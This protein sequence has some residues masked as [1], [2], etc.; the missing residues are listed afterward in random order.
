M[1]ANNIPIFFAC[2]DNYI[3]YLL[4]TLS[5]LKDHASKKYHYDL[6]IL[7]D[8]ISF[9]NRRK[10]KALECDNISIK[11]VNVTIRAMRLGDNLGIRDYYTKTTYF[12][13]L[14]PNLYPNLDKIL[15]LDADIVILEDI[16]N[17]YLTNIGDNLLGA[18]PDYSVNTFDEFAAYV[19]NALDIPRKRYMNAGILIMN[20]KR[21]RETNFERRTINL[22][23]TMTFPV[24][25]DQDILNI[26]CR[27]QIHYFSW[28]WDAMPLGVHIENPKIVH[29]NLIFKPWRL[30]DIP[31][32]EHF[33]KY[34]KMAGVY[35]KI[36]SAKGIVSPEQQAKELAELNNLKNGCLG[37]SLRGE[38]YQSNIALSQRSEEDLWP[39]Q[40]NLQNID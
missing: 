38:Y 7:F 12:R 35:D 26:I 13:L 24:A 8:H 19:E 34:A 6:H 25:Q 9:A 32:E 36:V 39:I 4:V 29:F 14:L 17:L 23:D 16:A 27:G 33:W 18:S 2:D 28:E 1:K 11:F 20:L 5:S 30:N 37:E 10:V 40:L 21:M 15:Y 31:Y 22:I 3:D